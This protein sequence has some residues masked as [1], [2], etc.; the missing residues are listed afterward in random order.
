MGHHGDGR[1]DPAEKTR[2]N[3]ILTI[4]TGILIVVFIGIRGGGI[5]KN[6]ENWHLK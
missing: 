5:R 1:L 4:A 6:E 3:Q 2:I